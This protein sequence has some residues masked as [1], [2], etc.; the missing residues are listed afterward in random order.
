[1]KTPN[2]ITCP[3]CKKGKLIRIQY[4]LCYCEQCGTE[5]ALGDD[6]IYRYVR[7]AHGEHKYVLIKKL[8]SK[9]VTHFRETLSHRHGEIR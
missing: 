9:Q 3:K 5:F 7:I 4:D 8:T 2:E 1:M 6:G